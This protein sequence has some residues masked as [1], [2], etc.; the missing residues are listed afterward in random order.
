MG[1]DSDKVASPPRRR[2]RKGEAKPEAPKVDAEEP[3][4]KTLGG[5]TE[6]SGNW[7]S[8]GRRRPGRKDWKGSIRI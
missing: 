7:F 2:R 5:A 8:V 1:D 3:A 4:L 6:D